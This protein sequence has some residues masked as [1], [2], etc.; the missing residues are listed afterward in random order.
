MR[1]AI[2]YFIALVVGGA[3]VSCDD[4]LK[5]ESGDLLIPQ[6]VSEFQALLYGEGYPRT[7]TREAGFLALMTDDI[8]IAFLGAGYTNTGK[9]ISLSNA[10]AAYTWDVA[11]EEMLPDEF[12][13]KR[14]A[15]IMCCNLI[16]NRLPEIEYTENEKGRYYYLAAQAYALRAYNYFCLVN[17]YAAPYS[18]ENL[19]KP[20]V[21]LRT[22]A[23]M[24]E[25]D[26]QLGRA[27]IREVYELINSD[28]V[29][30]QEYMDICTPSTNKHLIG[31]MAL[32]FLKNRVA[33]F[34][35]RWEEVIETGNEIIKD[36]GTFLYRD[37]R[38]T[39]PTAAELGS[40]SYTYQ[41]ATMFTMFDPGKN[42]EIIFTFGNTSPYRYM[43]DS[44]F[45]AIGAVTSKEGATGTEPA[46]DDTQRSLLAMYNAT[47]DRRLKAYFSDG[48]RTEE[49]GSQS[50]PIKY[51]GASAQPG[52]AECWRTVEVVLN[53]A[54]AYAR[55]EDYA[56]ARTQLSNLRAKRLTGSASGY[57]ITASN[58]PNNVVLKRVWAERRRELCFE[59]AMRFWDLR[60]QGM[61]SITHKYYTTETAYSTYVLP[62]GSP[63]YTL[64]I[65][66]S[67]FAYNGAIEQNP[68]D[69]IPQQ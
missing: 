6:G 53:V 31:P 19:D 2:K 29:K 50:I 57:N 24:K 35:E 55:T 26:M 58:T 60:R 69:V 47:T 52:Y 1:T 20:G 54:E 28:L 3:L 12:W 51:K 68:R 43:S 34:Q 38:G 44:N 9:D 13:P 16:I 39:T 8:E 25:D 46:L 30:A 37:I 27:T 59:E 67:E 17:V 21:I 66:A 4:Y 32:R 48:T 14:Y 64:P 18:E 41:G 5:N 42:T 11:M 63:N 10:D 62:Q 65:P 61:P 22:N 36:M 45:S 49:A 56:S 15:N 23:D 40:S 7:F 33:F